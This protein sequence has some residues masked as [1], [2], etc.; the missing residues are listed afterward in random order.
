MYLLVNVGRSYEPF[1][2]SNEERRIFDAWHSFQHPDYD[3]FSIS[4]IETRC[5]LKRIGTVTIASLHIKLEP[6]QLSSAKS[7]TKTSAKIVFKE[8]V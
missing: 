2:L 7:S 6:L 3:L 8:A 4:K 1:F 5:F